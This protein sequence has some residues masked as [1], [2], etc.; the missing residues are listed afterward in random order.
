MERAGLCSRLVHVSLPLHDARRWV[1]YDTEEKSGNEYEGHVGKKYQG[2]EGWS[3][4]GQAERLA[5][6]GTCEQLIIACWK[7]ALLQILNHLHYWSM[8][9]T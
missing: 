4:E 2:P 3:G 7:W 6:E 1:R 5:E 9:E 8:R